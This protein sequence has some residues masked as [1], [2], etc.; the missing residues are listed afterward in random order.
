MVVLETSR[1]THAEATSGQP[2]NDDPVLATVQA[3]I[4]SARL[5][6]TKPNEHPSGGVRSIPGVDHA[7]ATSGQPTNDDPVL[8]TVRAAIA[9]VC[10]GE[11]VGPRATGH[12]RNGAQPLTRL[13]PR[14]DKHN[15]PT[16]PLEIVNGR[17][18]NYRKGDTQVLPLG[19]QTSREAY[20]LG[21]RAQ[22]ERAWAKLIDIRRTAGQNSGSAAESYPDTL[23]GYP[24]VVNEIIR[25]LLMNNNATG[26]SL[27]DV[28]PWVQQLV[29]YY[30]GYPQ[31]TSDEP[32]YPVGD[33]A[34]VYLSLYNN[35]G[36][37]ATT[38]ARLYE[39]INKGDPEKAAN[40]ELQPPV[41]K[42]RK[43]TWR[44]GS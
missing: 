31:N 32:S 10:S 16:A 4:E 22:K 29:A 13:L 14:S 8:A 6:A 28:E 12:S 37:D 42:G 24:R 18:I 30:E 1:S 3:A 17:P 35:D 9:S 21:F 40:W 41:D 38:K 7:E 5:L 27:A 44:K 25:E 15:A 19:V 34:P 23:G 43:F 2:T 26:S 20:D 36:V 11:S 39:V 33:L